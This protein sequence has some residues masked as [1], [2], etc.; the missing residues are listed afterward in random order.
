MTEDSDRKMPHIW[1]GTVE[2]LVAAMKKTEAK[3]S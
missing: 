1:C 3:A 2:D